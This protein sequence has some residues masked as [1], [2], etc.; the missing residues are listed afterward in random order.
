MSIDPTSHISLWYI[1]SGSVN[2]VQQSEKVREA[3]SL[4]SPF[5]AL[6]TF[7]L[8]MFSHC[9]ANILFFVKMELSFLGLSFQKYANFV[10]IYFDLMLIVIYHWLLNTFKC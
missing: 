1:N 7:A 10:M 2:L 9:S 5:S 8:L 6:D 4:K 3:A